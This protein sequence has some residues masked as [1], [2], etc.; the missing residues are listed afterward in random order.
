MI[1]D[2]QVR[3]VARPKLDVHLGAATDRTAISNQSEMETTNQ[4]QIGRRVKLPG[5]FPEPVVLEG[6][7]PIGYRAKNVRL[8]DGTLDE[9]ILSRG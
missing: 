3:A 4:F 9:A 8:F 2:F 1:R 6:V 7:R 5:H